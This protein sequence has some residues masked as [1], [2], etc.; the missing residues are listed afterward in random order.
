MGENGYQLSP[1]PFCF[2][3][4]AGKVDDAG[5]HDLFAVIQVRI[6]THFHR[7]PAA[8]G[9][10][11]LEFPAGAHL[12]DFGI[13]QVLRSDPEVRKRPSTTPMLRIYQQEL[14]KA[15]QWAPPE[16]LESFSK[17]WLTDP[18]ILAWR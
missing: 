15:G 1:T 10:E 8:I 14:I 5:Q 4:S 13:A 16:A 12:A 6:Q 7:Y 3:A 2:L 18:I 11:R 9:P 17:Q